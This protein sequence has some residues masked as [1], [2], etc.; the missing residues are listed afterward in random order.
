MYHSQLERAFPPAFRELGCGSTGHFVSEVVSVQQ[1]EFLP[2]P[3]LKPFEEGLQSISLPSQDFGT[4]LG[5][6]KKDQPLYRHWAASLATVGQ[7]FT[8]FTDSG[9]PDYWLIYIIPTW[10]ATPGQIQ[11]TFVAVYQWQG[12]GREAEVYLCGGGSA[13]LVGT[14]EYLT[15]EGRTIGTNLV[16][17]GIVAVRNSDTD[18]YVYPGNG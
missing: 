10:S 16:N 13:R 11:P 2:Q 12:V 8:A 4:L 9:Y 18:V 14:S 1:S 6:H 17:F 15:V 5:T 7:S 3:E